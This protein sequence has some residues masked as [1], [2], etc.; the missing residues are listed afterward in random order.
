MSP[1]MAEQISTDWFDM[2]SQQL[3]ALKEDCQGLNDGSII[4]S[5]AVFEKAKLTVENI[6]RLADF[7]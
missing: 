1:Q 7:P 4:P 3:D 5:N 6:R 2:V